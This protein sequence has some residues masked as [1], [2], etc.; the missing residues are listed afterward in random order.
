MYKMKELVLIA[1]LGTFAGC[2]GSSDNSSSSDNNS[3]ATTTTTSSSSSSNSSLVDAEPIKKA[4][5]QVD[6][7]TVDVHKNSFDITTKLLNDVG[8]MLHSVAIINESVGN[9]LNLSMKLA[10]TLAK[11][12]GITETYKSLFSIKSDYNSSVPAFNITATLTNNYFLLSS[13]TPFF[14][15]KKTVKGYFKDASSLSDVWVKALADANKSKNLYFS[16]VEIDK[17]NITHKVSNALL[18]KSADLKNL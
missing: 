8:S 14:L 4:I 15:E 6:K 16:I 1:L 2:G 9:R 11:P 10:N 3:T 18:I 5:I 12:V 13:E 7:L 17:N